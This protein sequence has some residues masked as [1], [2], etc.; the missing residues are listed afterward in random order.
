MRLSW[1]IPCYNEEDIIEKTIREVD[2]YLRTKQFDHEILIVDNGSTDRT[3]EIV[4]SLMPQIAGLR[5]I[6][7]KEKGKGGAVKM[8]LSEANGDIR[9]FSDADNSVSPDHFD[10]MYSYFEQGY[11]VVVGSIEVPGAYIE[12]HA[13]WYRRALGH[14]AKLLIR[15]VSGVWEVRD[16][17]RGFKGFTRR[18]VGVI[19]PRVTIKTW[20]FDFE[21]LLIAKRHGLKIKEM[22]VRW[23]NPPGSKV[24]L[25]AYAS[26]LV[27]LFKVK[28]NDLAGRYE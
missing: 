7:A 27:E 15:L 12:E 13:Q 2:G 20:G 19:F 24:G 3:P 8:G 28:W 6:A 10:A 22:P 14:L 5:M 1:V 23:I 18:A 4:R 16:S 21:V 17:Q 9:L 11:D 26:T 25:S